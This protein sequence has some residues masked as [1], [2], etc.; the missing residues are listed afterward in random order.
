MTKRRLIGEAETTSEYDVEINDDLVQVSKFTGKNELCQLFA[1][2]KIGVGGGIC[3][4]SSEVGPNEIG[5]GFGIL[6][7][8]DLLSGSTSRCATY[9]NPCLICGNSNHFEVANI[10]VWSLSSYMFVSDAEKGEKALQLAKNNNYETPQS[11]SPWSQF[12]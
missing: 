8:G 2:D 4:P 6:L 12:L 9:N 1:D 11:I 3:I 5:D 7:E 10:E